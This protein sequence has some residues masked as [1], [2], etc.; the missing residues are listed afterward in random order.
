[1]NLEKVKELAKKH[2]DKAASDALKNAEDFAEDL[3]IEF[4]FPAIEAAVLKT[5][6][7]YDDAAYAALS[8][9]AAEMLKE[10]ISKISPA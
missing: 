7:K 4:I 8:P 1:M 6:N 10:L 3:L 2:A 5:E 9:K